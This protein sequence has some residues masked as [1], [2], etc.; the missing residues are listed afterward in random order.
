[1]DIG[2][3]MTNW[4]HSRKPNNDTSCLVSPLLCLSITLPLHYSASGLFDVFYHGNHFTMATI[5][6][7]HYHHPSILAISCYSS[8]KY[9]RLLHAPSF[10]CRQSFTKIKQ[11]G[12]LPKLLTSTALELAVPIKFQSVPCDSC[13]ILIA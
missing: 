13:R 9:N 11:P 7:P 5:A 12:N 8:S 1:M 2:Y 3:H 10:A 6:R 4:L